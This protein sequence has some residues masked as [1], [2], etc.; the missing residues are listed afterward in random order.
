MLML[1]LM[2]VLMRGDYPNNV[3]VIS[4]TRSSGYV[5]TPTFYRPV[6]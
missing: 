1:M 6:G 2:L 5:S 4:S 3:S